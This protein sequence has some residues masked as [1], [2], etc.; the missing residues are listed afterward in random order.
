MLDI[1]QLADLKHAFILRRKSESGNKQ[2]ANKD[3]VSLVVSY[4]GQV[5]VCG[6]R[7]SRLML[8]SGWY[9]TGGAWSEN[10]AWTE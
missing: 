9:I 1:R 4:V 5:C 3:H 6:G 2:E 10:K 7:G 8:V